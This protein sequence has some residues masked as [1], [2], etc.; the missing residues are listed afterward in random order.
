[1]NN[2]STILIIA[3][4]ALAIGSVEAY[5]QA[6]GVVLML[7]GMDFNELKEVL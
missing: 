3:G 6:A 2:M 5:M 7:C 1:M 4:L